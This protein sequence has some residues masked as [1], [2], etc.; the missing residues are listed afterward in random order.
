MLKAGTL[1]AQSTLDLLE[2]LLIPLGGL[3]PPPQVVSCIED[4]KPG[5]SFESSVFGRFLST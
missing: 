2:V 1:R 4:D 3:F 5:I